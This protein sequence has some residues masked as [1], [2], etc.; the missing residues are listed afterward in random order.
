MKASHFIFSVVM[1]AVLSGCAAKPVFVEP[2]APVTT[3]APVQAAPASPSAATLP[4]PA[5]TDDLLAEHQGK[6][7]KE[8]RKLIVVWVA[9]YCQGWADVT[10]GNFDACFQTTVIQTLAK[11]KQ[12]LA[13]A[14]IKP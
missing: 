8:A 2:P 10:G 4:S 6:S 5:V 1:A 14:P 12:P 11:L 7:D 9:G 3:P 13:A